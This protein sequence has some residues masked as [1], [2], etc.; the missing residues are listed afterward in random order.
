MYVI[1]GF[2]REV[3]DNYVITRKNVVLSKYLDERESVTYV[4]IILFV[5]DRCSYF[6]NLQFS[7]F[8]EHVYL[9]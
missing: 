4:L 5:S 6:P 1:S 9:R 3:N 8:E 7:Y 2:H